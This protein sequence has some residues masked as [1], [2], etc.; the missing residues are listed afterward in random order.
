MASDAQHPGESQ[1]AE[2]AAALLESLER[3]D[4]P[5]AFFRALLHGQLD[6]AEALH[7]AVWLPSAENR[8][9]VNLLVEEPARV[10]ARAA[11]AWRQPLARQ[12]AIVLLHGHRHVE[13]V[14]EPADRM[15]QGR[16]YWGISVP[17]PLGQSIAAVIAIVLPG[18]EQ[19][20]LD[21]ARAA[22]ESVA[23]QSLLFANL[24]AGQEMRQRYDELCAAWDLVAAVNA[25]YPDPDHMA[26]AF[27][28]KAKELCAVQRV[29]LGWARRGKVKL[30][31]VSEQ[32]YIDRRTNLARALVGAMEEADDLGHPLVF[33][34]A[35]PDAEAYEAHAMLADMADAHAIATYPL[36]ADEEVVACAVFER[37]ER[38]PFTEGE[39]RVQEIA[40]DQLGP[41]FGLARKSAR[42]PLARVRDGGAWLVETLAGKGH[43]V[44]KLVTL[45]VVSLVLVGI[46]G[47]WPLTISGDARLAPAVRRVYAAPF[48]RA[49]LSQTHVLPGDLVAA[50]DPL[51][52]FED[53]ELRISLRETRAKLAA[54]QRE[55]DTYFAQESM[56]KYKIARAQCGELEAQIELLEHRIAQTQVRATFDGVV[57]SGDLRQDVGTPFAMGDTLMEVAPLEELLLLAEVDQGDVAHVTPGQEGSFAT[58]ARPDIKLPFTVAKVRPMAESRD[59]SNVFVVEATV[60][61]TEGWLRPGMEAA[62]S[63]TGPRRNIA[64]VFTRK[65]TNWIRMKLFI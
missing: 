18:S 45:A 11:E 3:A 39:R 38:R 56:A 27:A 8:D 40:C 30:A 63:I 37:R 21:Y 7:G 4:S 26:L 23:A 46:F 25:G 19:A 20:A 50:G 5:Q 54:R 28:N 51:F 43:V 14:S 57:L 47:R 24:R 64:Y 55:R 13:R 44:A 36:R 41:P 16:P 65:L 10:G 29:S 6:R 17:V 32:D 58:K 48:E 34:D 62:A 1:Q 33:P 61:N 2:A 31:A 53:E 9:A 52:E 12:A 60:A 59:G 15:L 49:I 22:A 42:G 35:G